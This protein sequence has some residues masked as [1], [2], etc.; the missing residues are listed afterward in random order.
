MAS[1]RDEIATWSRLDRDVRRYE[2]RLGQAA[3]YAQPEHVTALLGPLP[4]RVGHAERWQTAAG[5]IEAYRTRWSIAGS[6]TLGPEPADPEQRAHWDRTVAIVGTAGFL[7]AGD[8]REGGSERTSLATRWDNAHKAIGQTVDDS[9]P[10]H[11]RIPSPAPLS[12]NESDLDYGFDNGF[13]L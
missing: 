2:Y 3:S 5:A 11:S 10:P 13:G 4:E 1:H 9:P 7:A 12:S 8:T 6:A